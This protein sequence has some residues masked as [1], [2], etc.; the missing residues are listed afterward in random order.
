MQ[1]NIPYS[2]ICEISMGY[3]HIIILKVVICG[4][5]KNLDKP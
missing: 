1:Q 4:K 3:L 5:Y 2:V